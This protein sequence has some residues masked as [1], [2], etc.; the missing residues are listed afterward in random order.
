MGH[1]DKAKKILLE[2]AWLRPKE[3]FKGDYFLFNGIDANDIR[4]GSLGV[5]Y[6]L[7]T[8]STLAQ[9]S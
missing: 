4:Q 3:I 6:M 9:D 2:L 7:A 5:C 1:N 8:L